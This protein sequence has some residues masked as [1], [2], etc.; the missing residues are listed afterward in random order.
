MRK[1]KTGVSLTPGHATPT[2]ARVPLKKDSTFLL[3]IERS[4][5]RHWKQEAKQRKISIAELIR[6]AMWMY[7][8]AKDTH[9]GQRNITDFAVPLAKTLERE[10]DPKLA[11]E[12]QRKP[13]RGKWRQPAAPAQVSVAF[14]NSKTGKTAAPSPSVA[15]TANPAHDPTC[16]CGI[17]EFRRIHLGGKKKE[18]KTRGRFRR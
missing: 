1:K 4:V 13:L 12:L 16:Q 7:I 18:E 2:R 8:A 6:N 9:L 3:K 5:L 17:C 10:M 14:F 11:D 15:P